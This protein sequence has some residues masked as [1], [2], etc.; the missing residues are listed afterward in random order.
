[1]IRQRECVSEDCPEGYHVWDNGSQ[2]FVCLGMKANDAIEAQ[3][4]VWRI[5]EQLPWSHFPP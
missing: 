2:Q 1:M 3:V 5:V 4:H